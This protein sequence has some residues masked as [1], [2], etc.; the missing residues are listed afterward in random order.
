[1]SIEEAE[2]ASRGQPA[3]ASNADLDRLISW[4]EIANYLNRG[5]RTVQVWEKCDG[6]PVHRH[7][8][9]RQSTVFAF[10]L[11]IDLW[12]CHRSASDRPSNRT[13]PL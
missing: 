11:E 5:I 8:R 9:N 12:W 10:R 13:S 3:N 2:T 7:F 6:L 4:K 1:M